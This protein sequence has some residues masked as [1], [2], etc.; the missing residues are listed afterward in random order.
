MMPP[1][2]FHEKIISIYARGITGPGRGMFWRPSL[3]PI[4]SCERAAAHM[5]QANRLPSMRANAAQWRS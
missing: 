5:G 2:D 3:C 4:A 1:P